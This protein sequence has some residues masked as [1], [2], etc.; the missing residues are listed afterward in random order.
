MPAPTVPGEIL[1]ERFLEM[2]S[3]E[4]NAAANTRAAYQRDLKDATKFMASR[5]VA[6]GDTATADLSAY[7]AAMD[8]KGLV[9]RSSARRLSA[10]RQ[11]FK[12][13]VAEQVRGD[14]P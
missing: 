2:L 7:L 9:A 1:V 8:K 13:L 5:K 14:D 12:F 3:A 11:F 6:L 4:R 10:L